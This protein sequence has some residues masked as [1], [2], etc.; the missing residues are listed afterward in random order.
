LI[1]IGFNISVLSDFFG[2][3]GSF[4]ITPLL[5]I[6][7]FPMINAV[8][9]GLTFPVIVSSFG[10][11]R[12]YLAGNTIIKI[13]LIVGF[14][15]FVG[16]RI[17][18]PLVIYLS[19]LNTAGFYIRMVYIILLL[20]LGILTL[21]KRQFAQSLSSIPHLSLLGRI[22]NLSPQINL[23]Y[24]YSPVSIWLIIGIALVI[25]FLQGFMGIVGGFIFVPWKLPIIL[26]EKH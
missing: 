4:I 20:V 23:G 14:I 26:P 6:L 24:S 7:G 22:R 9:T 15:S 17:S 12:H 10:G 2:V 3:E 8:G 11:I 18:Q 21:R 5:N 19:R 25:G 16:I 1:F 13:S